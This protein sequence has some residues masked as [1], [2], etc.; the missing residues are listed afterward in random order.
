[1]C[2]VEIEGIPKLQTSC[3]TPVRDGMVVHTPHRPGQ[4]GAERG[5]RVPARQPPARLPGLRQ[6]RRVPA[7]GHL[8]GLGPGQEP[9]DRPQAPL[10]EA[11][12]A[13]AAG[14]DRPRALHPLL[15]L[16]ALQPGGRRGRA[17]AAA[18]AR[19]PHLRR[20]LR[21]PPLHRPLPRQ[22]HRPLPGRG[23]DQLHLPLPRPALGHRAGRLGLHALPEPVQRQLH[24]PRRAGE[25]GARP[26]Q[27]RGRRRLALRPRPLR[28]R[29]VRRR[30]AGRPG[31]GCEGGAGGELGGRRSPRRRRGCARPAARA[32]AIVGDA[33]NEEGYL[34][35]RILREALGSPHID[36]RPSRGP[37]ARGAGRGS[38]SPSSRPEVRDIDDADAILV[39]GTDPLHSSPIL[40]LRIRKAIRRNGARLAVATERPTALDG[41]A[42]AIARYAPGE[43]RRTSSPSWQPPARRAT[44]TTTATPRLAERPAR[45][46]AASSIVWGER[47][48]REGD[49]AV[50][51]LLDLAAR[52]RPAPAR[53]ARACSKSP[54][55]ANA[56]GL[57]E[58]G[59]LPDAGPGLTRERR[60][61]GT[62][63]TEEIRA[64]LESGELK[65]LLL[66]GVD[67]LR[68]FPDTD[69]LGSAPSPP[70]TTSSPSRCSRPRPRP[71]PTS[72]SRWRP[73]PRKTA[74]SPTP[75]AASSASAPA[76][77]APATSARTGRSSPSSPRPSATTPASPP[78]PPPSPP[79]TDAV[80]F[81]AGITDAEI[82]G[83]GVRWQDRSASSARQLRERRPRAG[84]RRRRVAGH[85]AR[86][87]VRPTPECRAP[88]RPR[89]AALALGTYRDLWAGPITELNPPLQVPGAAAAARTVARRR[90]APRP[91]DG[92]EVEV[93][94]NGT[95]VARHGRDPGADRARAPAS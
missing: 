51:A 75:T 63:S 77:P 42:E 85:S 17:A 57:R 50:D 5:G 58:A 48:G 3:S 66:F 21:R 1:M 47:I 82:G 23:A 88:R 91:E 29:D 62:T 6:G 34:V 36:S 24:R 8:D 9:G 13:L 81:Y 69:G 92:D 27:R 35:Q 25:A 44:R 30:G 43:R 90:R 37:G 53:T 18:R 31:R 95:S 73:T 76:P 38:P 61:P 56:R 84:G 65:A 19:R 2:L 83:R 39:V 40:D 4:G 67:P 22:H 54:S 71:R 86:Q 64:A 28:L 55:V 59:C 33:S 72:S 70:P 74:P 89:T 93:A 60:Q 10:P 14:R 87:R 79:S 41:G 49:G 16:R 94:Q 45:R 26:R 46:R 68:D 20:H 52:P 11:D 78:S 12:R 80:P 7:A 15:P 32:A